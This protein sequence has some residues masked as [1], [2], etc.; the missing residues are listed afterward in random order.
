[1]LKALKFKSFYFI[2]INNGTKFYEHRFNYLRS[3][4][5]FCS[6]TRQNHFI[7]YFCSVVVDNNCL[8]LIGISFFF[9]SVVFRLLKRFDLSMLKKH[10][11][12]SV[13]IKKKN[14]INR[15]YTNTILCNRLSIFIPVN[16][17][18]NE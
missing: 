17:M 3:R 14:T 1:M 10:A 7:R 5:C 12:N 2:I 16:L 9:P 4:N 11:W 8:L 13:I 18:H 6:I 15:V